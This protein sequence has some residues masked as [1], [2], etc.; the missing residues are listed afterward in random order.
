MLLLTAGALYA[1]TAAYFALRVRNLS[2]D[3]AATFANIGALFTDIQACYLG[4]LAGA[5]AG[6]TGGATQCTTSQGLGDLV[7]PSDLPPQYCVGTAALTVNVSTLVTVDVDLGLW[8]SS[9]KWSHS[10]EC[11]CD[12]YRPYSGTR[13]SAGVH[14]RSGR[15]GAS[16]LSSSARSFSRPV[17]RCS[18]SA[19]C[20]ACSLQRLRTWTRT[21]T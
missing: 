20:G 3:V 16:S 5:G 8:S 1:G 4:S 9:S 18:C 12:M 19:V 13:S 17:V 15:S 11:L 21:Q 7:G 14:A 2:H 10:L 6:G